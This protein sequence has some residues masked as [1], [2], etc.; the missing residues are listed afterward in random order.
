[1][2][3]SRTKNR[4]VYLF[5]ALFVSMQVT[6]LHVLT[7]MDD[8]DGIVHCALCDYTIVNNQTPL[9]SPDTQEFNLG[10]V[11]FITKKETTR[12]FHFIYCDTAIPNH[13]FSRPPP[14]YL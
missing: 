8:D 2:G 14:A 7:H 9:L 6:G 13:L 5:L 10:Q 3:I 11:V 4:I 1:M 12:E